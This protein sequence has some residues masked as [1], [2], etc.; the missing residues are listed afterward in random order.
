M[1]CAMLAAHSVF[2]VLDHGQRWQLAR[3]AR[4]VNAASGELV[5][6][7]GDAATCMYLLV[8]GTVQCTLDDDDDGGC[9]ADTD[10]WAASH[11]PRR[12]SV[13][14]VKEPAAKLGISLTGDG[15]APPTLSAIER[16]SVAARAQLAVGQRLLAVNSTRC[17][18][19]HVHASRTLQAA[20]GRVHLCVSAMDDGVDA[21]DAAATAGTDDG[22]GGDSGG[23]G[24]GDSGSGGG[25]AL[26]CDPWLLL[27]C[28]S[29][30]QQRAH[31]HGQLSAWLATSRQ[32]IYLYRFYYRM[33]CRMT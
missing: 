4:A 12:K 6:R 33:T 11:A 21:S 27:Q 23:G 19:G 24:G 25:A 32:K 10:S 28:V 30:A 15:P 8:D 3:A 9:D 18:S 14:L 5:C 2:S 16:D 31:E 29:T 7:K 17:A 1:A 26:G 22:G 20:V 13:T